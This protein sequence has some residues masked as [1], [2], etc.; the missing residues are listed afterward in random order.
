MV[1]IGNLDQKK[2]LATVGQKI[3]LKPGT[4]PS[5]RSSGNAPQIGTLTRG[6]HS[7][8]VLSRNKLPKKPLARAEKEN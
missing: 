3:T 6:K 8:V 4:H 5:A 2:T 1:K 7:S